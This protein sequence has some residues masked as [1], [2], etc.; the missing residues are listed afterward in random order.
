MEKG[1]AETPE[2]AARKWYSNTKLF[3]KGELNAFI[4]GSKWQA[5]GMYTEKEVTEMLIEH[6]TEAYN[7][8][9]NMLSTIIE[10]ENKLKQLED[11]D[12]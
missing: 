4:A 6:L 5:E 8:K 9:H 10:L 2:E 7:K 11:G 12:N 3:D 1:H